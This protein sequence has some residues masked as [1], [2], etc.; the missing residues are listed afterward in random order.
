MLG[1]EMGL[2]AD[3]RTKGRSRE[4]LLD[5]YTL[6]SALNI[7]TELKKATTMLKMPTFMPEKQALTQTYTTKKSMAILTEMEGNNRSLYDFKS[8]LSAIQNVEMQEKTDKD[9]FDFIPTIQNATDE[10]FMVDDIDEDDRNE[11][12]SNAPSDLRSATTLS[13]D[14][15]RTPSEA[16]DDFISEMEKNASTF[17]YRRFLGPL[18]FPMAHVISILSPTLACNILLL[19]ITNRCV[20]VTLVRDY[21]VDWFVVLVLDR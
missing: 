21:R 4:T 20:F 3:A 13:D 11:V 9:D 19:L 10:N 15:T 5:L 8:K 18:D 7:V 2:A 17:D 6:A 14:F 1:L 12:A 16:Y